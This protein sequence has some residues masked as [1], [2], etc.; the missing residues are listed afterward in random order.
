MKKM[1]IIIFETKP[2]D[3]KFFKKELKQHS[4]T[5]VEEPLTEENAKKYK[6]A[7]IISTF[8][9]SKVN[10]KAISQMPKLKLITTRSTGY[11][12]IDL[13]EARK[14]KIIVSN[15]PQY[16]ANTVAEHTFAL[17]LNLSRHVHKSYLRTK[18]DNYKIEDLTGFDLQGKWLGVIGAGHIGQH[19]IKIA[20]GFGMHV[21]AYDKYQNEFLA[22]LLHFKY[23]DSIDELLRKAD[24]LT[25]HVPSL[26]STHHM[27]NKEAI[28]KMKKGAIIINTSRGDVIDT[29]ALYEALKSK[30]LG[31]AGLDVIEGEQY[32]KEDQE[33]L[34]THD[35]EKLSQLI[36]AKDIFKLDNVVFTPHNAF[37]SREALLR[38][39][40]VTKKNIT[41]FIEGKPIN[42]VN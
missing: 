18:N 12:H 6:N 19:V 3:K 29:D 11:D 14:R 17:I 33:L 27:I 37:N 38:I 24:I 30:K 40:E 4:L 1:K 36:R 2:R 8:I 25:L 26:P 9:R 16:G 13:K 35:P 15:V 22:E 34:A 41:S 23:A 7:E 28:S 39:L 32:I 42:K 10:K 31:G 21:I 20:K 5:F